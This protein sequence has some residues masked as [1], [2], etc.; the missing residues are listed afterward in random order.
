MEVDFQSL[1]EFPSPGMLRDWVN[2][3]GDVCKSVPL[4]SPSRW[5]YEY[6]RSANWRRRKKQQREI[7]QIFIGLVSVVN[8]LDAG[9]TYKCQTVSSISFDC[10]SQV[11]DAQHAALEGLLQGK[12]LCSGSPELRLVR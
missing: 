7:R 6:R 10:L 3:H 1:N 4:P 11:A 8:G 2:R 5:K 12:S 9:D